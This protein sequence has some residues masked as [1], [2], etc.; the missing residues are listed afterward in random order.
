MG[1]SSLSVDFLQDSEITGHSFTV[2]LFVHEFW[3]AWSVTI[4]VYL[5]PLP[6]IIWAKNE[7]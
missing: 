1:P 5:S 4:H 6:I 7:K 2:D 3:L